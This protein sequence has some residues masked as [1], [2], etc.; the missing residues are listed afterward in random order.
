MR[1][2]REKGGITISGMD[3]HDGKQSPLK[4]SDTEQGAKRPA[5]VSYRPPERLRDEFYVRAQNSGLS[6]NAF[7]TQSVFGASAARQ[8]GDRKLAAC[9]LSQAAQIN[10]R[11]ADLDQACQS[12]R[13]EAILQEC[14]DE[15][16]EIRAA[17]LKQM[18]KRS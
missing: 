16:A 11:L 18:G 14:R 3:A 9:L 12:A 1:G 15:L 13:Q 6:L 10:D 4:G 2:L 8:K 17:L 7:I 5:P